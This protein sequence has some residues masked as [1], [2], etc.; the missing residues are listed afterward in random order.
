[1]S[2]KLSIDGKR[3]HLIDRLEELEQCCVE[4]GKF[5]EI[6]VDT[7]FDRNRNR[8]GF[9]VCVIQVATPEDIYIIDPL[10]ISKKEDYSE[11]LRSLYLLMENPEITKIFHA[12]S[13]DLRLFAKK[14]CHVQNVFDTRV[15]AMVLCTKSDSFKILLKEFYEIDIDKSLQKSNWYNRPFT[16][17]DI[18]YL[19]NDVAFLISL[20]SKLTEQLELKDRK[21][22]FE[23]EMLNE[24]DFD[25]NQ[26]FDYN[27]SIVRSKGRFQ[28]LSE[29]KKSFFE[30]LWDFRGVFAKRLDI[31]PYFVFSDDT[32]FQLIE[33]EDIVQT[34]VVPTIHRRLKNND[35]ANLVTFL[36][37]TRAELEDAGLSK[38]YIREHPHHT[39]KRSVPFHDRKENIERV[40]EKFRPISGY[41]RER[42]DE[43]TE[44]FLLS[45][46]DLR[47]IA[48]SGNM[49]HMPMY[50]IEQ[51]M[52]AAK[53]TK[54][55]ISEYLV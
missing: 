24:L 18:Q 23:E 12:C 32:I 8:F 22:W 42:Y 3:V 35:E 2:L 44:L 15:A 52:V 53:H 11:K 13:E 10:S 19:A 34:T 20:K 4:I 51:V 36:L 37:K 54:V 39:V 40:V 28:Q 26:D 30:R 47:K 48:E 45:N 14:G 9:H 27:M 46:A 17:E 7:E 16:L 41:L 5:P 43:V 21:S 25:P 55:D 33:R 38:E 50:A 1:M 49:A 31:P 29:F 6:A